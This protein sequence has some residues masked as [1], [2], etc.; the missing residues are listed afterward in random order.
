MM[1]AVFWQ[2]KVEV[3]WRRIRLMLKALF[4]MEQYQFVIGRACK[5]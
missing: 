2:M 5:F 4:R 1:R 3:Q